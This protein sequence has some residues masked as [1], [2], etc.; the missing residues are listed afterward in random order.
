MER[1]SKA[2]DTGIYAVSV[3]LDIKT[4]DTLIYNI[5]LVKLEKN[6]TLEVN[7]T[8]GLRVTYETEDIMLKTITLN[9]IQKNVAHGVLQ[10]YII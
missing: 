5:L 8:D 6:M 9:P 4:P 10:C 1:V 3:F 7:S 2:F